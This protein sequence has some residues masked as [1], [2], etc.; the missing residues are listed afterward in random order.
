MSTFHN[1]T[2]LITGGASGI[3]KLMGKLAIE[4]G[5]KRL[6]IWDIN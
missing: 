4:K 2:L 3:G 5:I 6:I 1:K